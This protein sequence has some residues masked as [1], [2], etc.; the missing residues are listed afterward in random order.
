MMIVPRR[1][2]LLLVVLFAL[3]GCTGPD[4]EP[5]AAPEETTASEEPESETETETE[6]TEQEEASPRPSASSVPSEAIATAQGDRPDTRLEVLE[7][8][9]SGETLTLNFAIVNDSGEDI[10]FGLEEFTAQGDGQEHWETMSGVTLTDDAN[11][12]RHLVLREPDGICVCSIDV[13]ELPAGERGVFFAT[14]A[15]PPEDVT[16]MSVQVPNFGAIN[17]VPIS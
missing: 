17:A 14:F 9:R 2:V 4:D 13:N 7:L 12:R 16:E 10:S 11:S 5:E 1:N 8:R 6:E 3:V 15:A